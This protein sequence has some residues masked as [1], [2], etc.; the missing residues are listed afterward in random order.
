M[1]FNKKPRYPFKLYSTLLAEH[2]KS[3]HNDYIISISFS[4]ACNVLSISFSIACN[5]SS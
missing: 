2:Q 4:I 1:N 5:V 3:T